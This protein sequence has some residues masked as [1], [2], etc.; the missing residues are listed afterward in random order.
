M[1]HGIYTALITPFTTRDQLDTEGLAALIEFQLTQGVS[2]LVPI[3]T[4]G[5]SPTLLD[6][7][8][9][10]I[11]E[12]ICNQTN[13]RTTIIAGTGNSSTAHALAHCRRAAEHG[14]D[15]VLLVDPYYNGPSSLEIRREYIA[16]IAREMPPQLELIPYLVPARTGTRLEAQDL[17]LLAREFAHICTVKE[18]STPDHAAD[19]RRL[20]GGHFS[21]LCG[22]DRLNLELMQR[23][24]IA[25]NGAISV[26]ANIAPAALQTMYTYARSGQWREAE[27]IRRRL[28]PLCSI[29][30]VETVEQ[31]PCGPVRCRA[32]NPVPIKMLMQLLGMP[33]GPCRAPLGRLTRG[34]L[35]QVRRAVQQVLDTD[36]S[37]LEP[38]EHFFNVDI[39][40]R[41]AD[42]TLEETLVYSEYVSS[43][44]E[45]V[46]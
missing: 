33:A 23:S 25:A 45:N 10:Q 31:S 38:I 9:C 3:G 36:A 11:L 20:C 21:I 29:V 12:Q 17:A 44:A 37:I 14:A 16:P 41:L 5:E 4:T 13:G 19:I 1:L 34:G 7:E 42:P 22:E 18:A 40:A 39:A 8:R 24:D 2:G 30:Q 26:V 43:C 27:Q 28:A 35:I 32:R 15:G 46:L 6:T